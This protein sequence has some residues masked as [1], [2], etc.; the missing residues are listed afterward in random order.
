M[1]EEKK[2]SGS[3]YV[4]AAVS[5]VALVL[6]VLHL[7][8]PNLKID[9]YALAL[10]VVGVLPWLSSIIDSI[11]FPGGGGV[12]FKKEQERAREAGEA[13]VRASPPPAQSAVTRSARLAQ[14]AHLVPLSAEGVDSNLQFVA[15]RIAI[16]KKLAALMDERRLAGARTTGEALHQLRNAGVI[17]SEVAES[18]N[19]LIRVGNQAA[20]G[21]RIE[22]DLGRWAAD[23]GPEILA[24]LDRLAGAPPKS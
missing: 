20:H 6:L 2:D 15:L 16:E 17:N 10:L 24:A 13:I 19:N 1:A 18:L 22:E 23:R 5:V 3:G 7:S 8:L 4:K 14:A 12:T 21:K 11:Q 9:G